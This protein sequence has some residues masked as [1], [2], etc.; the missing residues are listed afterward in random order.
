MQKNWLVIIFEEKK[1]NNSLCYS[2]KNTSNRSSM[3]LCFE[4]PYGYKQRKF[5]LYGS[6]LDHGKANISLT[7]KQFHN[8]Y[9]R[10]KF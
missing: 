9:K 7:V 8:T 5:S 4:L 10:M 3:L 6:N 1:G 2:Q